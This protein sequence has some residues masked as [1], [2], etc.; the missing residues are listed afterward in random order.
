VQTKLLIAWEK[1]KLAEGLQ[2]ILS[3][4]RFG[5]LKKEVKKILAT[6]EWQKTV[7]LLEWPH[8]KP[9]LS[10]IPI[11]QCPRRAALG[12]FWIDQV[13]HLYSEPL[14]PKRHMVAAFGRIVGWQECFSVMDECLG[15]RRDKGT[16][17][18]VSIQ[19]CGTFIA[20]NFVGKIKCRQIY[21]AVSIYSY[22]QNYEQKTRFWSNQS[23]PSNWTQFSMGRSPHPSTA[24][25][26]PKEIDSLS[27]NMSVHCLEAS[28]F[29]YNTCF[30]WP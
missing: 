6:I 11:W 28:K 3:E 4:L 13:A 25:T 14:W 22:N 8:V 30:Y 23:E 24:V 19:C 1:L 15:G 2:K 9:L 20:S 12:L 26:I 27:S 29:H 7:F 5:H 18:V 10:M 17:T 16:M 21:T